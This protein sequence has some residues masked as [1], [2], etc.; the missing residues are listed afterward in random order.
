MLK[1]ENIKKIIDGMSNANDKLYMAELMTKVFTELSS[2]VENKYNSLENKIRASVDAVKPINIYVDKIEKQAD[3]SFLHPVCDDDFYDG[4]LADFEGSC[5]HIGLFFAKLSYKEIC[6]LLKSGLEI[7]NGLKFT[8]KKNEKY[9]DKIKELYEI[10]KDNRIAWRTVY[11]PYAYKFLD[12]F[13]SIDEN[14]ASNATLTEVLETEVL[15]KYSLKKGVIPRWN[16]KTITAD[17]K[18]FSAPASSPIENRILYEQ[19][20]IFQD[21]NMYLVVN[22]NEAPFEYVTFSQTERNRSISVYSETDKQTLWQMKAIMDKSY[23][24]IS[25][26]LENCLHNEEADSFVGDFADVKTKTVFAQCEVE[27]IIKGFGNDFI[28][29]ELTPDAKLSDKETYNCNLFLDNSN[30]EKKR[31]LLAKFKSTHE[32]NYLLYDR[33]SFLVSQ[34]ELVFPEYNWAG[35]IV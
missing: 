13:L 10:F 18:N 2:E 16:I 23:A 15:E 14:G 5:H 33:L 19:K 24:D 34:L 1:P 7:E 26:P 4:V 9:L 8:F 27:R 17:Q 29:K 20:A 35:E 6:N 22:S 30:T 12:V 11:F 31:T 28:L 32:K 25:C 3:G 21:S